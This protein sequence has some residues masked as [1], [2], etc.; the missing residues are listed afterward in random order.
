M[1]PW[2]AVLSDLLEGYLSSVQPLASYDTAPARLAL[3]SSLGRLG[4]PPAPSTPVSLQSSR[5]A[6]VRVAASRAQPLSRG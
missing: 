1:S 6:A 4:T 3:G 5:R 2:S